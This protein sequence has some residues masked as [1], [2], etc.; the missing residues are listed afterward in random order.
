MTC[1]IRNDLLVECRGVSVDKELED[2]FL[3]PLVVPAIPQRSY[4]VFQTP[5]RT[6]RSDLK[7]REMCDELYRTVRNLNLHSFSLGVSW[8][9]PGLEPAPSRT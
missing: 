2:L 1:L 6:N 9:D 4:F 7:D 5:I 3:Q 8:V